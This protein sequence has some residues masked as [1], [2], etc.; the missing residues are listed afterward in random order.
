MNDFFASAVTCDYSIFNKY[1][2]ENINTSSSHSVKKDV[3][4][5][6]NLI[7]YSY[8]YYTLSYL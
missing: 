8:M 2:F 4:T 5:Q 6:G 7:V 1:Y 3:I